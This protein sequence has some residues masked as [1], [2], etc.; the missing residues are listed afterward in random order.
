[1]GRDIR[2]LL[3]IS[4]EEE[5]LIWRRKERERSLR[6]RSRAFYRSLVSLRPFL[7]WSELEIRLAYQ[8]V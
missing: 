1:M 5:S 7:M 2:F 3:G 8:L 4:E 6:R